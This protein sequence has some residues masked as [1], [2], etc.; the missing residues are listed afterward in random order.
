MKFD[1]EAATLQHMKRV[2]ELLTEAAKE[3]I[4]RANNHDLSKLSKEEK[5]YFDELTPKLA[6][7]TFGSE[8]YLQSL[9]D[10]KPALHHHFSLN[11][12][13]P[14]FYKNGINGM[15]LFDIL[16]MFLDWKASGE[17]HED[18]NIYKSIEYNKKRFKM[19]DQLEKIFINT[20]KK[21]NYKE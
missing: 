10:L 11:S 6:T 12:H 1:S 18:G 7:T 15:N 17:R 19:S 2:A 3:L 13:H 16:E 9:K 20:A 5:P 8:E 21:M 14:E 4:D